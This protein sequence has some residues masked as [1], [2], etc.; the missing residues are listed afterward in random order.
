MAAASAWAPL[1]RVVELPAREARDG[2]ARAV[3]DAASS[4]PGSL[5][6]VVVDVNGGESREEM[7]H[8]REMLRGVAAATAGSGTSNSTKQTQTRVVVRVSGDWNETGRLAVDVACEWASCLCLVDVHTTRTEEDVED[9]HGSLTAFVN[10]GSP[11]S[12]LRRLEIRNSP[13]T[14]NLIWQLSQAMQRNV[15]LLEF[16]LAK[17][18][19]GGDQ[20]EE[21]IPAMRELASA[22]GRH[23]CLE[24]VDMMDVTWGAIAQLA[25]S[26]SLKAVRVWPLDVADAVV[27]E[28]LANVVDGCSQ[29]RTL[30]VE[31]VIFFRGDHADEGEAVYG[32]EAW[33]RFAHALASAPNLGA[34]V[35][36][37]LPPTCPVHVHNQIVQAIHTN[38][39]LQVVH[40]RGQ[41][42]STFSSKIMTSNATPD[43][44]ASG[45]GGDASSWTRRVPTLLSLDDKRSTEDAKERELELRSAAQALD[46]GAPRPMLAVTVGEAMALTRML[47]PLARRDSVG[48]HT[49]AII[50]EVAWI[51]FCL[52]VMFQIFQACP[53]WM[54]GVAACVV[55]VHLCVFTSRVWFPILL[56]GMDAVH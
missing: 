37:P 16:V 20:D 1:L 28:V 46:A 32:D 48:F 33:T 10:L 41:G 12:R 19:R 50:T 45:T 3:R 5:A 17:D 24:T 55:V 29:L 42:L 8:V 54:S 7:T 25:G 40:F 34:V 30:V 43:E 49:V 35:G 13:L 21:S 4:R 2:V 52:W 6:W 44:F 18:E 38:N 53:G 47:R 26:T 51:M 31:P 23:S 56:R 36:I 9:A 15:S 27:G 39:S 14:A 22:V 11:F